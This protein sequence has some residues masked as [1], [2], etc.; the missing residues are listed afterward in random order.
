MN[1]KAMAEAIRTERKAIWEGLM[2]PDP[3]IYRVKGRQCGITP[4]MMLSRHIPWSDLY[5]EDYF[6]RMKNFFAYPA[7][8]SEEERTSFIKTKW[9]LWAIKEKR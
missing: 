6:I 9:Q 7:N 5:V 3:P 2:K 1:Y 8:W 4:P